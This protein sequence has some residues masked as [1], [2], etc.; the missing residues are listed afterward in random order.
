MQSEDVRDVLLQPYVIE[1]LKE[2]G[3]PKRFKD[4]QDKITTSQT[5]SVKLS[6]LKRYGLIKPI[7]I[8]IDG[9]YVNAYTLS[10]KGKK[11]IK[12]LETI[13]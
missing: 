3:H 8:E 4:L 13:K 1:I 2:L 5:L 10:E 11:I 9:K 12:I 7:P 6:K